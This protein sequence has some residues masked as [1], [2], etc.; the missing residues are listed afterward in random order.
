MYFQV[1]QVTLTCPYQMASY[2]CHLCGYWC[3][4]TQLLHPVTRHCFLDCFA[5]LHFDHVIRLQVGQVI[6]TYPYQMALMGIIPAIC[7][8]IGVGLLNYYTL[9][10]L[11]VLYLERKRIMV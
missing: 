9:W 5:A 2:F 11:I 10:L 8:A 6:L 1:G 4:S 7:V 3:G